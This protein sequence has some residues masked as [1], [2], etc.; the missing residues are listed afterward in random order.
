MINNHMPHFSE[1]ASCEDYPAEWWF[2]EEV[3]GN[4]RQWSRTPEA[5]KARSICKECPAL[6]ECRSYALSYSGLAGIWAGQDWQERRE[7]QMKLGITPIHMTDT[8]DSGIF[9]MLTEGVKSDE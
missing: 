9:S 3:A 6:W 1:K 5:M 7:L 4:N 2:P 8:Y